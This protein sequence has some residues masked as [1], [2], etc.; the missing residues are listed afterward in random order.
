MG[1]VPSPPFGVRRGFAAW[2]IGVALSVAST[3]P[4]AAEGGVSGRVLRSDEPVQNAVVY[5]YQVVERTAQRVTTDGAGEFL[6]GALP[7]GL[8]KIVALK[9]GLP[10]AVLVLARRAATDSQYVQVELP[11]ADAPSNDFW[12]LRSEVPTDVLREL[13]PTA[14][15]L[16]SDFEP[17]QDLASR[18]ATDIVASASREPLAGTDAAAVAGADLNMSGDLGAVRLRIEGEFRNLAASLRD[19][20][21]GAGLGDAVRGRSAAIRLGLSGERAGDLG[22]SARTHA[23]DAPV[24]GTAL[25]PFDFAQYQIHYSRDFDTERSTDVSAQ[26]LDEQGLLANS[27]FAPRSLPFASR[28]LS[29]QGTYSQSLGDS[30]K[31][32]AGLRY[33]EIEKS[34]P[35]IAVNADSERYLDVWSNG[36]LDLSSAV[37]FQYGMYSTLR[38]GSVSLT[39]RGG[40]LVHLSPS[41][42]ASVSASHR[43][44][45]SDLDPLA[46]DYTPL[47]F[48][49]AL[50][51][52]QADTTCYETQLM[53]GESDLSGFAI[54][55]SWRQF[56]RTARMLLREDF[57]TPPDGV[58]FVPGDQL[59]EMQTT[60]K[61]QLGSSVA[62]SWVSSYASGG[63]G[64][65]RAA[66]RRN[67]TNGIEL[68]TTALD[69]QI[70]PS[71]T[72]F[73]LAYQRVAQ[74]LDPV[75]LPNRRGPKP[76]ATQL[77]R[78]EFA[79]S[80]DLSAIFDM[81]SDWAVRVAMELVRGGTLLAPV[82][83]ESDIRHG[84]TT[85]VAVRF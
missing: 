6:F 13:S 67:Y 10:P 51:C 24:S 61:R 47:L 39:P 41:W 45:T 8:Y 16:A 78:V 74:R 40:V 48:L 53:N 54:R 43:F 69:T 22:I 26:Y 31:L 35:S 9:S 49:G 28:T 80:Q 21:A 73:Y 33:R 62:A 58:F 7:A 50:G 46:E 32:V 5:A 76:V 34:G 79:V 1:G 37:V 3:V 25:D 14:I 66:N 30:G 55:G 23:L 19:D 71:S 11:D 18:F 57:S 64:Q 27:R 63:G 56:D 75:A 20:G 85:S 60:F 81:A 29:V 59:P 52:E 2:S 42:R 68:Y 17:Q 36:D 84:V 38:D 4:A 44:V 82:E 15:V 83:N 77:D 65:F 72:G 70:L 12:N